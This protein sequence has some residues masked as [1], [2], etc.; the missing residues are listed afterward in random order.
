MKRITDLAGVFGLLLLVGIMTLVCHS[1]PEAGASLAFI[2]L[3]AGM[4]AKGITLTDDQEKFI[5]ELDSGV[6][7]SLTEQKKLGEDLAKQIKAMQDQAELDKKD[8]EKDAKDKEANQK[9]LDALIAKSKE[10]PGGFPQIKSFEQHLEDGLTKNEA[11]LKGF[12][13]RENGGANGFKVDIDKKAVGNL[14]TS[15]NITGSYFVPPTVVPGVITKLYEETHVRDIL[16][17]GNTNSNVIRY[18]RD[19]GGEGGPA[20]VAEAGTKPQIDRDLQIYDA[21]VRKIATYF[22]V[23]EEM[24]EDIPYLSSFLTQIGLEEVMVV[25][26]NQLLYGDGTGQNIS[27][28]F[29]N[30]TAFAAGTSVIGASSNNFDVVLAAKKQLRVAKVGGP[31][32]GLVSPVDWFAMRTKK[33]TTNNYLFLGGGNGIDLG[34]NIDGVRLIE[35]T[36]ITADDFIIFQPRAAQIFDRTG[37]AVRFFDQDQDNAIKNLITIVIEKREALA[38]YRPLAIVKGT[39]STAITDLTS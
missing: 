16:P 21:N 3:V 5:N 6:E 10:L 1:S 23:P 24:I 13:N 28:L 31:L 12:R 39:F 20:M 37:T 38:I 22:R 29:T 35:H 25:E 11:K 30:A 17:V 14:G 34:L 26:D 8:K 2:G 18:I 4:K 7:K 19:N 36:A 33:D 15:A 27:G 9:A 32:V